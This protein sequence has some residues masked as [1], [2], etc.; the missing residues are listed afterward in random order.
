MNITFRFDSGYMGESWYTVEGDGER[1]L[2]RLRTEASEYMRGI[3]TAKGDDFDREYTSSIGILRSDKSYQ[4][5]RGL[6]NPEVLEAFNTWRKRDHEEQ[7]NKMR[8]QPERYD[9]PGMKPLEEEFPEPVAALAGYYRMDLGWIVGAPQD[10]ESAK[11][12]E[13]VTWAAF[14]EI[15]HKVRTMVEAREYALAAW[16]R[17]SANKGVA[18]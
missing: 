16:A 14:S 13:A 8:S 7:L 5:I 17:Q 15:F 4:G 12:F 10:M 11:F 9:Y 1:Y 18:Q 6:V 3:S 2:V